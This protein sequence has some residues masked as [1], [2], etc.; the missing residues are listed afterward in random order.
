MGKILSLARQDHVHAAVHRFERLL[1]ADRVVGAEALHEFIEHGA[2]D[3]AMGTFAAAEDHFYFHL[4]SLFKEFSCLVHADLQVARPNTHRETNALDFHFLG[5][6][7]L[8]A[9][10]FFLLIFEV[11]EIGEF[12]HWWLSLWGNLNEV[13]SF[14]G[15]EID[16]L[17]RL[18]DAERNAGIINHSDLWGE[19]MMIR[20][21]IRCFKLWLL[22]LSVTVD[23]HGLLVNLLE[24]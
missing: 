20:L 10:L 4:I 21:E 16:C 22:E 8:L 6:S 18:H 2:G 13:E 19:N 17:C 7:A 23:A 14:F 24:W 11:A 12:A 5:L 3:V 1:H 15:R 9:H